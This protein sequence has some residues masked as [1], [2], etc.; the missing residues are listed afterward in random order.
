[1][2]KDVQDKSRQEYDM[3]CKS[4]GIEDYNDSLRYNTQNSHQSAQ[5]RLNRELSKDKVAKLVRD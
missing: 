5:N 1:M 4:L 2:R 3:N